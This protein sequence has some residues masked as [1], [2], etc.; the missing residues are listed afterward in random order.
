MAFEYDHV[1]QPPWV[2]PT[3]SLF[4]RHQEGGYPPF[5]LLAP[6]LAS[7]IASTLASTLASPHAPPFEAQEE[8]PVEID[9]VACG[10]PFP[11]AEVVCLDSDAVARRHPRHNAVARRH[12]R[13]KP[14]VNPQSIKQWREWPDLYRVMHKNYDCRKFF[15]NYPLALNRK[16]VW[17]LCHGETDVYRHETRSGFCYYLTHDNRYIKPDPTTGAGLGDHV[18]VDTQQSE[19]QLSLRQSLSKRS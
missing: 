1:P 6:S 18:W 11:R 14:F 15:W 9:A 10:D 2:F 3:P 13:E 8:P 7:P 17:R 16:L 4:G 5:G 19:R 12:P